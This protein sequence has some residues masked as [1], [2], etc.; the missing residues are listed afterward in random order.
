VLA[1]SERFTV[2]VADMAQGTLN[3]RYLDAT[4]D[5]DTAEPLAVCERLEARGLVERDGNGRGSTLAG[6]A[7]RERGRVDP[8]P[9]TGRRR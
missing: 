4:P 3:D 9:R 1:W 7:L 2:T 8:A 5:F 6:V